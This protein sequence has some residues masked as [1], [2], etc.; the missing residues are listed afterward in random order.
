M[1]TQN[2]PAPSG[3]P[4]SSATPPSRRETLL[5]AGAIV[6]TV[7][8]WAS[9]FLVIRGVAPHLAP[10]GLAF[11]RLIVG[12]L[13]L[14]VLFA[15]S[16]RWVT[17]TAR[18]WMLLLGYGVLWFGLYNVALNTAETTLDAGT[19]AMIVNV[20]P[21]LIALGGGLIFHE[22][23]SRWL[24][25]GFVVAFAGIVLI[26]V[27]SGAHFGDLGGMLWCLVAAVTYAAGVLTQKPTLRRLPGIQVTLFGALIGAVVTT[28]FAPQLV[29]DLGRVAH[30]TPHSLSPVVLGIVYLGVV[31]TALAFT[32]WAYALGRVPASRLG[33]STYV[34]PPIAVLLGWAAFGEVPAPLA[35][36]GGVVCLAG[37]A[38]SRRRSRPA[39]V[40][41]E[42]APVSEASPGR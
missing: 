29:G 34:V 25:I 23:I 5:L 39:V 31:P 17:P 28:P 12:A 19:T 40:V 11:G 38:L 9:A 36:V 8:A 30:D 14:I 1:S 41:S 32:T 20:G 2:V 7:L 3:I 35:L 4:S 13:A 21:I 6:F 26:G 37:V 10:G 15:I 27:A 33:I 16:R 24:A 18:E 22:G 42:Q